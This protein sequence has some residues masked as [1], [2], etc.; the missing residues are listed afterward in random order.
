MT[1]TLERRLLQSVCAPACP[2]AAMCGRDSH[3]GPPGR[4]KVRVIR[5]CMNAKKCTLLYL[6]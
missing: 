2:V 6:I 4:G 3:Y 1:P 5:S